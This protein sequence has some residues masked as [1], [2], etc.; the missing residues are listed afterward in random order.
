MTIPA[1][2]HSISGLRDL[3][4]DYDLILCDVWG[5]VHDGVVHTPSAADALTRFR[6]GGGRI[7]L[8]TNAP[9]PSDDI[10]PMLDRM[11][12]ARTAYDGIVS[13]GDVTVALMAAR[14][15]ELVYHLGPRRDEHLFAAFSRLTGR[16]DPRAALEAADYMVCSGLFSDDDPIEPYLP[17]LRTAAARGLPMICANPDIVVH[18]GDRLVYCAGALAREYEAMGASV[19]QAGKP[20][21]A[22]YRQALARA[23]ELGAKPDPR[24]LAIGDGMFTDMAG[25]AAQGIDAL[26]ISGGIH[27]DAVLGAGGFDAAACRAL[28][29]EA[30]AAPRAQSPALVW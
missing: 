7:V 15:G 16:P 28:A 3:A 29:A 20:H 6:A 11:G 21:A 12:L 18:V 17:G 23:A 25:A 14:A 2:L 22:I 19:M 4:G 10:V 9:R 1:R 24:V 30:K 13:S 8:L 5:V 26:F 27:R